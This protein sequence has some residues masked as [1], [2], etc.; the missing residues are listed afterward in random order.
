MS[1]PHG[2]RIRETLTPVSPTQQ[3]H[4]VD[5]SRLQSSPVSLSSSQSGRCLHYNLS[6]PTPKVNVDETSSASHLS[7]DYR[8]SADNSPKPKIFCISWQMPTYGP[9]RYGLLFR[10]G[11]WEWRSPSTRTAPAFPV[12]GDPVL[13]TNVN[14]APVCH[15]L[16][17][18]G[19]TLPKSVEHNYG[20]SVRKSLRNPEET[21]KVP[22]VITLVLPNSPSQIAHLYLQV[23]IPAYSH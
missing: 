18:R 12:P 8:Q 1:A 17:T 14:G 22:I 10:Q 4:P 5:S 23:I 3:L 21:F 19:E 16:P 2:A 13:E 7:Q 20:N 15:T 9:A 11:T 6:S